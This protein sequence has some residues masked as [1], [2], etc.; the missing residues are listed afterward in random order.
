MD[1]TMAPTRHLIR[2]LSRYWRSR[3]V[4]REVLGEIPPQYSFSHCFTMMPTEAE[5]RLRMRLENQSAFSQTAARGARGVGVSV[6][7]YAGCVELTNGGLFEKLLSWADICCKAARTG[8]VVGAGC[9]SWY[10]CTLNAVR[11]AEN[12]PAW[13]RFVSRVPP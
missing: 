5:E 1:M 10:D 13:F 6:C 3:A 12:K 7:R 11:M 9:K 8:S 4:S 2:L